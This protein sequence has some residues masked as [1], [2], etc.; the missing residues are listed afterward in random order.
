M[1]TS[2]FA[3]A[4]KLV[5]SSKL[6]HTEI[7]IASNETWPPI[8]FYSFFVMGLEIKKMQNISSFLSRK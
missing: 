1:M 5:N 8:F 7:E 6:P 3:E 4:G 2:L